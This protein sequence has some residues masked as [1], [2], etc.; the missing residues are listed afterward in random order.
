MKPSKGICELDDFGNEI[1]YRLICDCG[2][3][4]CN[5]DVEL[6]KDKDDYCTLYLTLNQNL[7]LQRY[8]SLWD[9]FKAL[10]KI[11]FVGE[12]NVYGCTI[13]N[14]EQIEDFIDALND[15]K[16]RLKND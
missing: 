12:I 11:L 10:C 15:G 7:S 8:D 6:S 14:K 5:C 4:Q 13:L 16:D 2:G 3:D 1:W 9:R